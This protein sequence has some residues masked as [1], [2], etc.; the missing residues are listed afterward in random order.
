MIEESLVNKENITT[1]ANLSFI[2]NFN[3]INESMLFLDQ[4]EYLPSDILVKSDRNS[5]AVG[6]ENRAKDLRFNQS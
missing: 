2:K 4:L 1:T 6:L 3:N 5:M